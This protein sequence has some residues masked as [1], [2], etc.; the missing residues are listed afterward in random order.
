MPILR[1]PILR[2]LLVAVVAGMLALLAGPAAQAT[3]I[4]AGP[5]WNNADAQGKCPD[6][7]RKAG[8]GRWTGQWRTLPG[9]ATSVCDCD[10]PRPSSGP[11]PRSALVEAGPLWNQMDAQNKCPGVCAQSGGRSW[12]GNWKTTDPGRMS[13]C[14][15]VGASSGGGH[16]SGGNYPSGG[17]YG[18]P[19][20]GSGY[21]GPTGGDGW[22][23]PGDGM[24]A[25]SGF[26]LIGGGNSCRA[27]SRGGCPGC[28]VSCPGGQQASCR[29]GVTWNDKFNN[30][31][32]SCVN[33]S[34][35]TC[36]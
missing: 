29:E 23:R 27:P 11:T 6:V 2:A 28:S 34:Q 20:G 16:S 3:E 35:C 21:G 9:T 26:P 4:G 10:L 24:G 17:G 15:C 13:V 30:G 14:S 22:T 8:D 1:L 33:Q 18:G 36:R 32:H 7:C 19:A 25:P 12:D 5:I 31:D